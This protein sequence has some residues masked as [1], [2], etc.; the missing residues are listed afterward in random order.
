MGIAALL[1]GKVEDTRHKVAVVVS[2]SNVDVPLLLRLAQQCADRRSVASSA[3]SEGL[4]TA[5]LAQ[6]IV[7]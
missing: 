3:A 2:G 4:R 5:R 6:R 7:R 1:G